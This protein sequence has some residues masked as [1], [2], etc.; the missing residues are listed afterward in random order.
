MFTSFPS[1]FVITFFV[2]SG[3]FIARSLMVKNYSPLIFYGDRMI[4]IYIPFIG[5]MLLAYWF[6]IFAYNINSEL[7]D[8]VSN[9]PYNREIIAAYQDM[10]MISFL[11]ALFFLPGESGFYFANNNPYWSLFYE[12]LFYIIIPFVI[13]FCN[14]NRYLFTFLMLMFVLSLLG[15]TGGLTIFSFLVNYSTYFLAGVLLFQYS[16]EKKY[17]IVLLKTVRKYTNFFIVLSA[18][19]LLGSI[20]FG[21]I[22]YEKIGYFFCMIGTIFIILWILYGSRTTLFKILNRIIINPFS[23][24]LGK[25][26]FSLY[27]VH[28]PFF[29]LLYSIL[30]KY[31]GEIIFY[32]R[33]YWVAVIFA[34]PIGYISYLIFEKNSLVLLD[35]YKKKYSYLKKVQ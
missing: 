34:L 13:A 24:F 35:K 1:V 27:L 4:R 19:F 2:L 20:P 5:S 31:T 15:I 6:M 11:K 18:L 7:V 26:S 8:I 12:A 21:I 22:G 29:V 28:V 25:I 17:R 33:I 16:H 14:R 9:R 3:F 30:V 23:N 32:D 10:N